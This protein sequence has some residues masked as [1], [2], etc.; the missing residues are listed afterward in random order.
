MR[1]DQAGPH[2]G[3]LQVRD[4]HPVDAVDRRQ[5]GQQRLEQAEVAE[6]LAVGRRVL[7][8]EEQLA[9]AACRRAS[10]PRRG[11]RPGAARRTS[12]G[13]P[14]WRRTSTAGRSR[15]PASAAPRA[16]RRAAGARRA[17]RTPAPAR[18]AGPGHPR[19]TSSAPAG[20]ACRSAGASGSSVRRSRG[21]WDSGRSPWR[22]PSRCAGQV[23]VGVEAEDGVRLRQ[24]AGQLLA[25]PLGQAP[26]GDHRLRGRRRR[27]PAGRRPRAGCR[28]S[29]SSPARRTRR[30]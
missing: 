1:L 4:A 13:R 15:R 28:S 30:C 23:G 2:L 27:P 24:R 20:G 26:D 17:G 14:G 29:P 8:D 21:T 6:V 19:R 22:M 3:G 9:H 18:P 12:R 10:A 25:V 16:A 5:L 11:R 7:A